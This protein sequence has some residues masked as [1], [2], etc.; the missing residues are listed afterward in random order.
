MQTK[1][2]SIANIGLYADKVYG[3]WFQRGIVMEASQESVLSAEE[4]AEKLSGI[5]RMK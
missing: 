4:L 5:G 3:T 2:T 1:S